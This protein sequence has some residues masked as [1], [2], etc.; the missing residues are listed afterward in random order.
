MDTLEVLQK[1]AKELGEPLGYE[2]LITM[3]K[4]L[5][6]QMDADKLAELVKKVLAFKNAENQCL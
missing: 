1:I 5:D 6:E 4:L 2:S 3:L